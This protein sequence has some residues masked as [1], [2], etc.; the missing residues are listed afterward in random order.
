[1]PRGTAKSASSLN[2]ED[3]LHPEDYFASI[4]QPQTLRK[5][6]LAAV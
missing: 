6:M 4:D 1:M 5:A 3:Y 2:R